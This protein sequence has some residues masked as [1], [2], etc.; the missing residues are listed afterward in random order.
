MSTGWRSR[1]T[2]AVTNLCRLCDRDPNFFGDRVL[3]FYL[4]LGGQ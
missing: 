1:S 4:K 2:T 3:S